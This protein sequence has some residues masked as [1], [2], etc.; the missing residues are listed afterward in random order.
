MPTAKRTG[1]GFVA[2]AFFGIAVAALTSRPTTD[3]L[4]AKS[5]ALAVSGWSRLHLIELGTDW[6][7]NTRHSNDRLM[8]CRHVVRVSDFEIG[9]NCAREATTIAD[10]G[11]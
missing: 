6:P 4:A 11:T 7:T 3:T 1:L 10:A 9:F 5:Y 2:F 8:F